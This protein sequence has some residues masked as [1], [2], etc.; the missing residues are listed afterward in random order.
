MTK[1]LKN[2]FIILF[3]VFAFMF[4]GF[5]FVGCDIDYDKISLTSSTKNVEIEVGESVDIYFKI[6]NYQSGFDNKININTVKGK[7]EK[8]EV[9]K[10]SDEVS[11]LSEDRMKITITGVDGGS[12][13]IYA[14]TSDG[15]KECYVNVNVKKYATSMSSNNSTLYVSNKSEFIPSDVLFNLGERTT[16]T[17]L[18]Y[19]YFK[20]KTDANLN[21]FYLDQINEEENKVIFA[22]GQGDF[23]EGDIKRFEKVKLV[24]EDGQNNIYLVD[25]ENE[26]KIDLVSSFLMLSV[27]NHSIQNRESGSKI[28]YSI[29]EVNVLPSLDVEVYGGYLN[30]VTGKIDFEKV[31]NNEISIVPNNDKM[32]F[33][34]LKFVVSSVL[35]DNEIIDIE[36]KLESKYLDI[37]FFEYDEENQEGKKVVYFKVLRIAPIQED[38]DFGF[39]IFYNIAQN[40]QDESVNF[41]MDFVA[42][43]K[44]A[45]AVIAINGS[46]E[47]AD[48]E[49]YSNSISQ[50]G[51]KDVLVEVLSNSNEDATF[52]GV[53]FVYDESNLDFMT[54]KGVPVKNGVLYTDLSEPF[55][56]RG[57]SSSDSEE[58][59]LVYLQSDILPDGDR[60]ECELN[61]KVIEGASDIQYDEDYS[62]RNIFINANGE[63]AELK[64]VLYANKAFQSV[65]FEF[66]SGTDVA[67]ISSGDE[68]YV[69][70][71]VSHKYYLNIEVF[72]KKTGVGTYR[73]VLDNGVSKEITFES[74]KVLSDDSTNVVLADE[75]NGAVKKVSFDKDEESEFNNILNI[76][77][78]NESSKDEV[79]GGSTADIRI[80][81][82]GFILDPRVDEG[83]V[84]AVKFGE[85]GVRFITAS[86]GKSVVYI[87]LSGFYIDEKFDR[88]DKTIKITV[89]IYAYSILSEFYLRN[90]NESA[91]NNVIYY[92]VSKDSNI[93]T[94]LSSVSFNIVANNAESYSFYKYDLEGKT[95]KRLFEEGVPSSVGRDNKINAN[96]ITKQLCYEKYNNKFVYYYIQYA[97]SAIKNLQTEIVITKKVEGEDDVSKNFTINLLNAMAFYGYGEDEKEKNVVFYDVDENGSKIAEYYV[98]YSNVY[99][100]GNYRFNTE[101]LTFTTTAE[102][103]SPIDYSIV[104]NIEQSQ[105]NKKFNARI[106][107]REFLSVEGV[108]LASSETKLNFSNKNLTQNLGVY[109]YPAYATNKK[110]KFDFVTTGDNEYSDL[111][112]YSITQ[113]DNDSGIY[114]VS[115]SCEKFYQK[116]KEEITKINCSLTG[117]IYIYPEEWGNSYSAISST[118]GRS[119]EIIKIAV[120]YRNGSLMN[121]YLLETAE[122]VLNI[123]LNSNYEIASTIDMSG[124]KNFTPIGV[125][126]GQVVGFSGTIVGSSSTAGIKNINISNDNFC[127]EGENQTYYGLFA[128]LNSSSIIENILFEGSFNIDNV[129]NKAY[130]GLLTAENESEIANVGAE[131]EESSIRSEKDMWFGGLVGINNGVVAQDF[132]RYSGEG[133]TYG[134]NSDYFTKGYRYIKF[135]ESPI[136]TDNARYVVHDEKQ[137]LVDEENYYINESGIR[138]V[139]L[140]NDIDIDEDNVHVEDVAMST[141]WNYAGQKS[142][143]LAYFNGF[144]S[145]EMSNENSNLYAGGV[146]GESKGLIKRFTTSEY[147]M[148]GFA[149]YSAYTKISVSGEANNVYAGGVVGTITGAQI[150]DETV[151]TSGMDAPNV[152]LNLLVG[153]EVST[154]DCESNNDYVGGLVGLFE[155]I[156]STVSG[157]TSRVF[158]RGNQY[159]GAIAGRENYVSDTLIVWKNNKIEAVD[160]G[161]DAFDSAMIIR[162]QASS[163]SSKENTAEISFE[164]SYYAFGSSGRTYNI[165]TDSTGET[166]NEFFVRSYLNRNRISEDNIDENNRSTNDY[167]GDCV[168]FKKNSTEIGRHYFVKKDTAINVQATN[169]FDGNELLFMYYFGVKGLAN[170]EYDAASIDAVAE[171]NK[172][173]PNIDGDNSR[174]FYPF[175]ITSEDV[176]IT[177]VESNILSI[178]N[179]GNIDVKGTGLAVV[180]LSSILNVNVRQNVYIY[181]VNYFDKKVQTSVYYTSPSTNGVLV[182]T[183]SIVAV[184]GDS[185]TSLYVVPNYYLETRKTVDGNEFSVSEDGI[186]HFAGVNYVV[187]KNTMISTNYELKTDNSATDA[188]VNKQTIVFTADKNLVG[189]DINGKSDDYVL[190]PVLKV[191]VTIEG[192]GTKEYCYA[193]SGAE[194]GVSAVYKE[195]ATAI[196]PQSSYNNLKTNETWSESVFVETNNEDERLFYKIYKI[197]DDEISGENM[198]L[199]QN[200][201][202]TNESEVETYEFEIDQ[203]D[204]FDLI[205]VKD[206]QNSNVFNFNLQV[207]RSSIDFI[208]RYENNIY[209]RYRVQLYANELE[210]GVTSSFEFDLEEAQVGYVSITNYSN[211][212]SVVFDEEVVVPSQT[213]LLEI[214]IDPIEAVFDEITISNNEIN[215]R[216]GSGSAEFIFAYEKNDGGQISY[217]TVP[218]FA[219]TVN[220]KITFKYA[221]II[222]FLDDESRNAVGYK[223]KVY[224]AYF[225]SSYNIE[226]NV[227]VCFDVSVSYGNGL[228]ETATRTLYTK[229]LSYARLKFRNKKPLGD[230]YYVAKGL[231]YILDLDAYGFTPDQVSVTSTDDTVANISY[232][233]GVYVLNVTSANIVY[234]NDK[235]YKVEITTQAS[236]I[237]D[238]VEFR[239]APQ[240][241]TVYVM[242]YVVNYAY[243]EGVN[244]D[245]VKGMEN[246]VIRT[247]IGSP[248][249][250]EIDSSAFIE[251][252]KSNAEVGQEVELFLSKLTSSVKWKVYLNGVP[253]DIEKTSN[254]KTE[255]YLINGLTFTPLKLYSAS[256]GAYYLTAETN[257]TI[258][259][260]VYG[261]ASDASASSY[262]LY[263]EFSF[264]VYNQSTEDSPIPVESYED[265]I[266][267][268]EGQWYILLND[269]VL[270]SEEYAQTNGVEAFSPITTKIAGFDG[271]G[272]KI[273]MQGTYNFDGS[274]FGIFARV[275]DGTVLK[276]VEVDIVSAVIFKTSA[277]SYNVGILASNNSGVITNC[278][279]NSI[280]GA[281]VSVVSTISS[282]ESY[283]GGLVASN[284]GFITNSRVSV[285]MFANVNL[286]GF[287][288]QNS[289]VIASSY[290]K[291]PKVAQDIG[292]GRFA[293]LKNETETTSEFTAGFVVLNSGRIYTSYVSGDV[294]NCTSDAYYSE[295]ENT[296]TSSNNISG[297]A[298]TN[299]GNIEDCYSNIKLSSGAYAAGFVFENAGN[300]ERCFS[301]SVLASRQ[302]SNYGFAYKNSVNNTVGNIED[303]YYLSDIIKSVSGDVIKEINVSIGEISD[304][305]ID[306]LTIAEFGQIDKY[307]K[308]YVV[309]NEIG[310]DSVWFFSEGVSSDVLGREFNI[311]RIELVAPN[312][313]AKSIKELERVETIVDEETGVSYANYVYNY[314]VD[315]GKIGSLYNPFVIY[316]AENFEKLI[317]QENNSANQNKSHY[318]LACDIDFEDY[319]YNSALYKTIF[320]GTLE[321]N[322]MSVNGISISSNEALNYAGLFAA[323]GFAGDEESIGAVMNLTI[324]PKNVSFINAQVVG[325]IAG[326]I[327]NATIVNVNVNIEN[328]NEKVIAVGGNI[329]GGVVGLAIGDYKIQN[330]VSQI[331]VRAEKKSSSSSYEEGVNIASCSYAGSIVGVLADSGYVYNINV[332]SEIDVLGDKAG[333]VFGFV[334]KNVVA[335]K[336]VL[337]MMNNHTINAYS[338]GGFVAGESKGTL[339]D[340]TIN[341]SGIFTNFRKTPSIPKAV[342][343]VVGLAN[344]GLIENVYT[345][346]SIQVTTKSTDD[347]GVAYLGGVVGIMSANTIL[348]NITVQNITLSGYKFVGG[349]VGCIESDDG[350]VQATNISV[351]GCTLI[352]SARYIEL[353]GAGGFVGFLADKCVVNLNVESD[354]SEYRN[355][356]QINSINTTSYVYNTAVNTYVGAVFGCVESDAAQF[357]SNTTSNV[358]DIKSYVYN[359]SSSKGQ[360]ED[361]NKDQGDNDIEYADYIGNGNGSTLGTILF[362]RTYDE[363]GSSSGRYKFVVSQCK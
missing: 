344:G 30:Y 154:K 50:Y 144:V 151:S 262:K 95:L 18:S 279:V 124:V 51:Y 338:Y 309:K 141:A 175:N 314:T 275:N 278:F 75:G 203:Y 283:V 179:S 128:K 207:N 83:S 40:V 38:V 348:R 271:N 150:P 208:N 170:G 157:N 242:E 260:G 312:I 304:A 330:A 264:D 118:D 286:A 45:P 158:V 90:G 107:V 233:N 3:G 174:K 331:G 195:A 229:L 235:G 143:N 48:M 236:K 93:D 120:Q 65:S 303:C 108:S 339:K 282:A 86:N 76:D 265:F 200:K 77:I 238:G 67:E 28:L 194:I 132:L 146:A 328:S 181:V 273:V 26:E 360:D 62:G 33:Y 46:S 188:Q 122:D 116:Y 168:E 2:M 6:E 356:F 276:N 317:L 9:F 129:N 66:V 357:V 147:K 127:F 13:M 15:K 171:L 103:S 287:A 27:Y 32:R 98:S 353:I 206:A 82:N 84:N 293:S 125:S 205:F 159:V 213:G 313:I 54:S 161:R 318:R 244:E 315:S 139:R 101:N 292:D 255:Y 290:F 74:I 221:D 263:T 291:S 163:V 350:A 193:L 268:Q 352:V 258:S 246:G 165:E 256:S 111:I 123:E 155:E 302:T 58:K 288:G 257:Y 96:E 37:D 361:T 250:L 202:P 270:P 209:G 142:K 336:I 160:E 225:V 320:M 191:L 59:I 237:V 340:I 134:S 226:D 85:N 153:G 81:S 117:M 269:I 230:D 190:T 343:G 92:S 267:M 308:N 176:S 183:G 220:G 14:K 131:I 109:V 277:S 11:Y 172:L 199:V 307:F 156:S 234:G 8:Y 333:L 164:N 351:S 324:V 112:S 73:V 301:T 56:V 363:S 306:S 36:K 295:E 319:E 186:L 285:N 53:Y 63:I 44:I 222:K 34:V 10:C 70:D 31:E 248:Y 149:G 119:R 69:Y 196:M 218:T 327:E 91:G 362:S 4:A 254:F 61:C 21:L 20:P 23:V 189:Q 253:R 305:V 68:V 284:D 52:D 197:E 173:S 310:V 43:I 251:Y 145:I 247:P 1:K 130:I 323:V 5:F 87:E 16:E 228:K 137:Y 325:G 354:D 79:R 29:D 223:G 216:S 104:A 210:N 296:I 335:E 166:I 241:L 55:R 198:I 272:K 346:Q 60:I 64:D 212:N 232:Q 299:N 185:N 347:N 281:T 227:P 126:N 140:D 71:E 24:S 266:G 49:L 121:P 192:Q 259:A 39:K 177:S 80:Y 204:L 184:Y 240:I 113:T 42:K 88:K 17:D 99:T 148:Y 294:S 19:F 245:I 169:V 341:G 114:I 359:M 94:N 78:L 274:E 342:G 334:D 100:I 152:L 178:D 215:Y 329:V 22:D 211:I 249:N 326:K 133:K 337:N 217:V 57:K 115:V 182:K 106:S 35:E 201:M 239:P 289:G 167:Y 97:G 180:T 136:I 349:V 162:Y 138:Y 47:P 298:Y 322:F 355:I 252:D 25:G 214:N 243:V 7:N 135:S 231:S 300:V 219:L 316:D 110:I 89:N 297:F 280:E 345:N 332:D 41:D 224:V 12:G 102:T 187:D 321:G 311:G 72:A 261:I 105:L 358:N